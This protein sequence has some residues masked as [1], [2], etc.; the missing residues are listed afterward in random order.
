M[1]LRA[2]TVKQ[3]LAYRRHS[4]HFPQ[5]VEIQFALLLKFYEYN[6]MRHLIPVNL[7]KY[8]MN[9][10]AGILMFQTLYSKHLCASGNHFVNSEGWTIAPKKSPCSS[11]S[12]ATAYRFDD[13]ILNAIHFD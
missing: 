3:I 1:E 7:G 9:H 6:I 10:F 12:Q 2:K 11:C 13:D 5:S 4:F 8:E